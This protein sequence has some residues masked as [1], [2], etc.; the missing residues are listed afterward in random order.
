[1]GEKIDLSIVIRCSDDIRVKNCLDSIDKIVDETIVVLNGATEE[2]RA[3]LNEYMNEY[4]LQKVELEER[5]MPLAQNKGIEEAKNERVLLMDSDCV[6]A[7]EAIYRMYDTS[8]TH[9]IVRGKVIFRSGN[10]F[11]R[12]AANIR[13]YHDS[14]DVRALT[15]LLLIRKGVRE[16]IGGYFFDA[17]IPKTH[18][19]EFDGRVKKAGI[20]IK[21]VPEAIAFHDEIGL[22]QDLIGAFRFGG[23]L[24]HQLRRKGKQFNLPYQMKRT[25]IKT[26]EIFR[27]YDL[28]TAIYYSL[29]WKPS[30]VLGYFT[31]MIK[32]KDD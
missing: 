2:V 32:P 17:S 24:Y 12:I 10:A 28:V 30:Y 4:N 23:G 5:N 3:I 16:R 8:Q 18:D 27:R 31:E 13:E 6:F 9:E 14:N 11:S 20:E 21:Y 1:M 29:C 7:R 19:E 15:P 22:F 26:K 25:I